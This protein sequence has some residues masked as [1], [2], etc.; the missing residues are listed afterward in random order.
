MRRRKQERERGERYCGGKLLCFSRSA[1][2]SSFL[3]PLGMSPS[4]R[5]RGGRKGDGLPRD[6]TERQ[7]TICARTLRGVKKKLLA[8]LLSWLFLV[9]G[10]LSLVSYRDSSK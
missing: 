9:L 6:A 7:G 1:A 4:E 3:F 5:E 2:L 10:R 8:G